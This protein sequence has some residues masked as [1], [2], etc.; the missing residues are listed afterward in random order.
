MT[1][2]T[3]E[4]LRQ[5]ATTKQLRVRISNDAA[6]RLAAL[7]DAQFRTPQQQA[8]WMLEQALTRD[9]HSEEC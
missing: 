5:A 9:G 6:A 2:E 1:T 4:K 3:M 8:S 7:A